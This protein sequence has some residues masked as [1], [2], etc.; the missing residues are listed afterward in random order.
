MEIML[1]RAFLS[2]TALTRDPYYAGGELFAA[3]AKDVARIHALAQRMWPRLEEAAPGEV[4]VY[5]EGQ[6]LSVIYELLD[7]PIGTA[8]PHIRRMWTAVRLNNV[9]W[10]DIDSSRCVWH[11][12]MEKKLGFVEL[13][14]VIRDPDSWFWRVAPEHLRLKIAKTMGLPRPTTW[15]WVNKVRIRALEQFALWQSTQPRNPRSEIQV[16]ADS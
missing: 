8:D 5:E 16:R 11:L 10:E 1:S 3:T 7:V 2:G 4:A 12:P 15:Q 14:A 13:F 6:F 9:T